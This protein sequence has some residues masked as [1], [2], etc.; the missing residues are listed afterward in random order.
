MP[1]KGANFMITTDL[2]VFIVF[3]QGMASFLSPC[4][5]PLIPAYLTYLTGQSAEVMLRD[6]K[7]HKTLIWNGLAFVI[8]FSAVF[9][10][11][12]A[13]ATGLGK[14]FLKNNEIFR[15]VSGVVVIIFGLF[16]MGLI[17]ISFLNY[18]KRLQIANKA[19]G[20]TGSLLMGVG[21]SFGWTPC[22][23]PV[24]SAVLILASRSSTVWNG[25]GLLAV[26]SLGLGIPFIALTIFLRYLWKYI[27]GIYR[28]MK[29]IKIVSGVMLVLIGVLILTN[30][31]GYLATF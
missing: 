15:Q 26:Y 7:A 11:L 10:L 13:T 8:G 30:T 6:P 14:F 16:H 12:G 5:L 1:V 24:L 23:G 4:V 9:I 3:I 28:Y 19:P 25:I 18:E 31:L 22:I 21:F 27:K 29:A 17:P 2:S 20:L